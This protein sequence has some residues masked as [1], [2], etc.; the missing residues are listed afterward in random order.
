MKKALLALTLLFSSTSVFAASDCEIARPMASPVIHL[1]VQAL[2]MHKADTSYQEIAQWRVKTF[3]PEIEKIIEANKLPP[4]A[5]MDPD[6]EVT[7]DVYNDVMMRSK[8]YVG[9]VYSYAR[10]G[11][12][13]SEVNDQRIMINDAYQK[14]VTKCTTNNVDS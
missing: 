13:K 6:L 3:N 11:I 1:V 10:G 9:M 2:R 8:I 5:F 12:D 14:Y 4:S 7:R